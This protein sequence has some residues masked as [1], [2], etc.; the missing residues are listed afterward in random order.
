MRKFA[1]RRVLCIDCTKRKYLCLQQIFYHLPAILAEV[2]EDKRDMHPAGSGLGILFPYQLVKREIL[3]D[4]FKPLAAFLHV[5]VDADIGSLPFQVLAVAH[6][7]H[8]PVQLFTAV[9]AADP[10]RLVHGRAQRLQHVGRKVHQTDEWLD[11]W[12]IVDALRL[13]GR[14]GVELFYCEVHGHGCFHI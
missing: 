5:A 14:A 2:W 12:L 4:I 11:G 8:G 10:D 9:A 13:G 7:A 1:S 6:T 3:F